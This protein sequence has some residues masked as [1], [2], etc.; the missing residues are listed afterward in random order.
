MNVESKKKKKGKKKGRITPF[1]KG[2]PHRC[3][4]H[5]GDM[6]SEDRAERPGAHG[7]RRRTR[8]EKPISDFPQVQ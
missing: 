2:T 1:G 8:Q 6:G 5:L 3:E 7:E 4:N